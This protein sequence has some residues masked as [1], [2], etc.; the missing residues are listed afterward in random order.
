[1]QALNLLNDPAF[2]EIARGLG[3]RMVREGG[4]EVKGRLAYG[5]RLVTGRLP[6]QGETDRL[7][8]LFDSERQ[9]FKNSGTASQLLAMTRAAEKPLPGQTLAVDEQ[10]A[11]TLVANVL[12]N[13]D[14]MQTKE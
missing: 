14:E 10:A 5:F 7:A 8:R 12:L 4:K 13:L 2:V 3:D 1:L 6:K 9:R 11:Y